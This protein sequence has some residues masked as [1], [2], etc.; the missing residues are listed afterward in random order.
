L[1]VEPLVVRIDLAG[2]N[3]ETELQCYQDYKETTN[4]RLCLIDEPLVVRI[5]LAGWNMETELQCY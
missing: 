5:D 3:I 4:S 2:W 1:I